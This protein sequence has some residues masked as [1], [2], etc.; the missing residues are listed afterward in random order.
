[1][2]IPNIGPIHFVWIDNDPPP[3]E[4]V[5]F[6]EKSGI[7]LVATRNSF[8][9]TMARDYEGHLTPAASARFFLPK[10]LEQFP[11][12]RFLYLDGDV[13]VKGS[14]GALAET[15]LPHGYIAAAEEYSRLFHT[16]ESR[17]TLAWKK[18][19]MIWECL[20]SPPTLTPESF[21]RICRLGRKL[22]PR[23]GFFFLKTLRSAPITINVR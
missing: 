18:K 20:R 10:L 17:S 9:S 7:I 23:H 3:F 11:I 4:L 12:D 22:L 5:S 15:D 21:S 2:E 16:D 1:M 6:L 13:E 14:L 8:L 19:F